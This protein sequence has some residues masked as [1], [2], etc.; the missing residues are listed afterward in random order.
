MYHLEYV[1]CRSFGTVAFA[2]LITSSAR[3]VR[4]IVRAIQASLN[5]TLEKRTKKALI[6]SSCGK[7]IRFFEETVGWF[8]SIHTCACR[9][10]RRCT[11]PRRI[12]INSLVPSQPHPWT[13]NKQRGPSPFIHWQNVCFRNCGVYLLLG[14]VCCN[15]SVYGIR[16]LDV[17]C[18]DY[19]SVLRDG[20]FD[21]CGWNNVFM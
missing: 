5:L 20:Y 9:V 18:C 2:S 15:E 4:F 1:A 16:V 3:T 17:Y 14:W 10:N 12:P 21:S 6:P 7:V 19:D 13:P 11:L 8:I